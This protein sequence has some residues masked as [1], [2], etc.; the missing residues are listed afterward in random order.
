[1]KKKFYAA[2]L[3]VAVIAFTGYNVYQSQKADAS[4]S[5]LAMANVEALA[6]GV[7]RGKQLNTIV[8][9]QR[10]D[11]FAP[12]GDLAYCGVELTFVLIMIEI[13]VKQVD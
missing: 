1:M 12:L 10:A 9:L 8:R 5:D 4:L 2:L 13:V 6:N 11:I 3:A 7:R